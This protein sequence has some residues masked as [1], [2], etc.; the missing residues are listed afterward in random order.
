M[1]T[2]RLLVGAPGHEISLKVVGGRITEVGSPSYNWAI[3]KDLTK[4][5]AWLVQKHI[6]WKYCGWRKK[7]EESTS[8]GDSSSD[9]SRSVFGST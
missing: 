5:T 1:S 2:K 3:C 7:C 8:S 9:G 6:P 4:V